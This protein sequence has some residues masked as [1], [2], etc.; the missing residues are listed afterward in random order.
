MIERLA[1][2]FSGVFQGCCVQVREHFDDTLI[3]FECSIRE[4]H[5]NNFCLTLEPLIICLLGQRR[6]GGHVDRAVQ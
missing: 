2:S 3:T 5:E 4:H 6:A 1:R